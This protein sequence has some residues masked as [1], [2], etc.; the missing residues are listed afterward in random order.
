MLGLAP[1]LDALGLDL[2]V[3][4]GTASIFAETAL[5]RGANVHAVGFVSDD[6]LASLF[7]QAICFAFPSRTEGFGIPLLEAMVHGAPIVA[8]DCASMPEVAGDAA[9]YAPADDPAVWLAQI[10]RL[11]Q[12]ATLREELRVKGRARYPRFSW[13]DGARAYLDLALALSPQTADGPRSTRA[14]VAGRAA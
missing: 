6:D 5:A 13:R 2:V 11:T 10:T 12:D 8:S 14:A 7:A 4:G 9:L 1:A 3:S